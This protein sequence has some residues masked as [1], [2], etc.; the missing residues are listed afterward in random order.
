MR[1][2]TSFLVA[3]ILV[4]QTIPSVYGEDVQIQ[5]DSSVYQTPEDSQPAP[6]APTVTKPVKPFT[7]FTG[8]T[9]KSKVRVRLQ[10]NLD[11]PILREISKNEIFVVV[12]ETDDFYAIEA[13]SD[14]K[15]Y[16]FRTY[17]LDNV[18][19][20]SRVNV[21]LEPNLDSPIIA[22]LHTGD[23]VD[24]Q[25][26]PLNSKWMEI[27]PPSSTRFYIA[28]DYV[29]NI[30]NAD[31]K[32]SLDV[33]KEEGLRL[34][35]STF[36]ISQTEMHKEWNQINIDPL[37]NNLNK[38]VDSYPEFPEL[39]SKAKE[40]LTMIQESYVQKK[41][42]YLENLAQNMDLI[43]A[44]KAAQNQPEIAQAEIAIETPS[45][46]SS[47]PNIPS[48][49]S[50]A[51]KMNTW[52]PVEN[53]YFESWSEI[54]DNQAI[55]TFYD[56]QMQHAVTLK[57]IIQPYERSI[58]NKPGD[59]VLLNANTRVPVAYLYSTRVNLQ[60]LVGQEKTIKVSPRDNNNFAYPAYFVLGVE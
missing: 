25:V 2:A 34:L 26:S 19:E 16:V 8:K 56:E 52:L 20:G 54:H 22:Q 27:A 12:G 28:K 31:L 1:K 49:L 3:T 46:E 13:P 47:A 40:L 4:A 51:D 18:I 57:G 33:K 37:T 35:N 38:I 32:A 55:S 9:V 48:T 17:V 23:H 36:A 60:D 39:Q 45:I 44:H 15:G 7:A 14:I 5:S 10:P 42:A 11:A 53:R 30:G 58:R 50:A 24:G 59:F 41:M 21:R 29:D 43:N 6:V